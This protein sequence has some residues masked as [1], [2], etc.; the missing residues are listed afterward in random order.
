M[1]GRLS[2][3]PI[4]KAALCRVKLPGNLI[5]QDR[6]G[7]PAICVR[8]A[9]KYIRPV[10]VGSEYARFVRDGSGGGRRF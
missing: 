10:V 9:Q 8:G 3:L 1:A 2:L 6:D 7:M 5:G 4:R